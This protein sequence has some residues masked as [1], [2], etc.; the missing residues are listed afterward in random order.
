MKYMDID[1][2]AILNKA[3]PEVESKLLAP[4]GLKKYKQYMSEYLQTNNRRE[5]LFSPYPSQIYYTTNDIDKWFTYTGVDKKII[6]NAIKE[7][8]YWP[9]PNFNPRYAKDESTVALLCMVRLFAL[10]RKKYEQE[11][12]LSLVNIAFSGKF[13][14]SIFHGKFM[15]TPAPHIM[16]YVV[17]QMMNPRYDL[18]KYGSIIGAIR[19]LSDTWLNTYI[20]D[21]FKTFTDEDVKYLVQQLHSRMVLFMQNIAELFYKAHNEMKNA[22][23]TYDSDNLSEDNFYVADNDSYKINRVVDNAVTEITTK[24]IDYLIA[25]RSS[26]NL[27]RMDE[28]VAIFESL[29]SNKDNIPIIREFIMLLVSIY[30]QTVSDRDKSVK[31]IAFITNSIK[32]MPN[33]RDPYILRKKELM[34]MILINNSANFARRRNRAATESAYYK[35][36]N[37]YLALLI[38]KA[39]K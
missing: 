6:K 24:N 28:L 22:F 37:A 9:I 30:F 11:L 5:A 19:S 16:E 10:D 36:F 23:I 1:T 33:S 27:V 20:D 21:R 26:N 15:H 2:T 31:D 39:N 29:I 12:N 13:Y 14:P 34:E 17:N 7:T 18:V 25:K 35:A 3:Y 32:P 38:Q 4:N 8:Y